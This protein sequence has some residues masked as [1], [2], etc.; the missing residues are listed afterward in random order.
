MPVYFVADNGAGFD[1]A[2]AKGLFRPFQR[3][4]RESEFP[5][6]GIG[7]ATVVRAV[8]R[9]GGAIWAHGA[10]NQG[11]TFHFSLTPGAQ[12]PAS[13]ATGEDVVPAWQPTDRGR[14][15]MIKD[16]PAV[17]LVE[18]NPDDEELTIRGLKRANLTNPVDV[19]RDGQ[20]AL[21]YLFGTEDQ[22]AKPAPAWFCSTSSSRGSTV[23]KSSSGSA[24]RT[25]PPGAGRDP[26][27]LKR[28]R[29]PHQ[30]IRPRGQQLRLQTDPVRRIRHRNRAARR[31]LADHQRTSPPGEQR[32]PS[33]HRR[34]RKPSSGS[35]LVAGGG[36][37]L[38]NSTTAGQV[39]L[40][41]RIFP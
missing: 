24:P 25:H 32:H 37:F 38:A 41:V 10:V 12:P 17:L 13:A 31:L 15:P 23:S 2:H 9:H 16:A 11:A 27:E 35:G 8:H 22:A 29:R 30:R 26:D 20:E 36:A 4:H 3:L 19:A 5:G 18:D 1:M 34:P 39:R 14:R 40:L 21:D 6:N 7:L 28:R 33:R